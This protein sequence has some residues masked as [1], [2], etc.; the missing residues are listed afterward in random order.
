[1]RSAF[2]ASCAIAA[3]GCPASDAGPCPTEVVAEAPAIVGAQ[4]ARVADRVAWMETNPDR[5]VLTAIDGSIGTSSAQSGLYAFGRAMA[6]DGDTL[7]WTATLEGITDSALF[8]T[9]LSGTTTTVATFPGCTG[10]VG[11]VID[12]GAWWVGCGDTV[13]TEV[14]T[15]PAP[16][17]I[18]V[19]PGYALTEDGIVDL[20]TAAEIP[21]PTLD[22]RRFARR[23]DRFYVVGSDQLFEVAL[24]GASRELGRN[25]I[26]AL[27]L[28]VDADAAYVA[29]NM[30]DDPDLYRV[31]LDG[32]DPK[33]DPEI[34][35]VDLGSA[36]AQ[37]DT[38]VYW[39]VRGRMTPTAGV[40]RT[41][42]CR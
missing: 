4:L 10:P 38:H 39:A 24:D 11:V 27:E 42:K 28:V 32:D 36:L 22:P 21:V 6:V 20:A 40:Y 25:M 37:D 18:D 29:T 2:L 33:L 8:A 26:G 5:V 35:A 19:V 41:E 12:G 17:L 16:G 3:A 14:A 7:Y 9:E 1:M 34:V 23:G 13:Y 15:Y 31:P 30:D